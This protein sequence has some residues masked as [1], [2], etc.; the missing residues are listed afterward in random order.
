MS[1]K[2]MILLIAG[3]IVALV[4]VCI[5]VV[6]L[7]DGIWPWDGITAYSRLLDPPTEPTTAPTE[8]EDPTDENAEG[9][10]EGNNQQGGAIEQTQATVGTLP[11]EDDIQV[12]VDINGVTN[13][14]GSA[15]STDSTEGSGEGS[16]GEEPEDDWTGSASQVPGWGS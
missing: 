13:P 2:N 14:T 6:G 11:I 8:P 4:L 10:A 16:Y 12:G 7:V 1:R 5:L 3:G 15:G 9:N